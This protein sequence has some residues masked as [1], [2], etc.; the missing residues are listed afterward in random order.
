METEKNLLTIK[1][2]CREFGGITRQT[3]R[4]YNIPHVRIGGRV[5]Y[6]N[7]NI[8]DIKRIGLKEFLNSPPADES[9]HKE[10]VC[11]Y[12]RGEM[13]SNRF[14][15]T[16]IQT[17]LNWDTQTTNIVK[18]FIEAG[19]QCIDIPDSAYVCVYETDEAVYNG[20]FVVFEAAE[21]NSAFELERIREKTKQM[22]SNISRY[23]ILPT[24]VA[25]C[26]YEQILDY[27]YIIDTVKFCI[28][29]MENQQKLL[30]F[31]L[32]FLGEK[33]KAEMAADPVIYKE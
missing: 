27:Q 26:L 32:P 1:E 6:R 31:M 14:K 16:M 20:T 24:E 33:F 23:N 12:E 3:L 21:D 7:E 29:A 25:R 28:D 4:N 30:N 15:L 11:E 17:I 19:N 2:T 5:F 22:D 9:V 18:G 13:N 8:Q 10:G